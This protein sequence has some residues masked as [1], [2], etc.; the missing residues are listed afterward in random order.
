MR[1]AVYRSY[2]PP[3]VVRVES[4]PTPE[5]RD[6]EVLIRVG[7]ST[8][9]SAD[10]RARSLAMP[11]G[12][13]PFARLVFGLRRPRKPILGSELAGEIAAVGRAVTRFRVGDPV[14]A[15]PG[16]ALG[17]HA[18]YRVM[19]ERGRLVPRP[20]GVTLEEAAA[21]AFGGTTALHFLRD[22]GTVQ[23]GE[24]ILVVGAAGAVGSAAVQ[25]AR[26]LGA[27]VTGVTST[28]NVER[29]LGLGAHRVVDYTAERYLDDADRY[30]VI[31]DTVGAVATAA[32]LRAL[33]GGGRLLLG[34]GGLAQVLGAA[35][36]SRRGGK[37]VLAGAAPERLEHLR[38]L[39]ALAAAGHYRPL[40][41]RVY[42][43]DRIVEAHARVETGRKQ[44]SVVIT[45]A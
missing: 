3:E 16:F 7:A 40:V 34:A 18:E 14:I 42:P 43:L 22:R 35:R 9:S 26:H 12:F 19:S 5:P 45:M 17:C 2:G 29:V 32:G 10:W 33:R 20:A 11:P 1:A 8:V 25:L 31:F 44:G 15:F 23:P 39:A 27:R 28:R 6:D 38:D 30:D 13:G 21:I 41:D 24:E 4:V 37:R 36:G